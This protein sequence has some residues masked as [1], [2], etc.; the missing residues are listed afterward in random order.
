[1]Q[2]IYIYV[3]IYVYV[4]KFWQFTKWGEKFIVPRGEVVGL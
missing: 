1:M 2:S 3:R 4:A